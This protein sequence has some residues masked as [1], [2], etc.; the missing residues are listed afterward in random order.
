[1]GTTK[2]QPDASFGTKVCFWAETL[3]NEMKHISRNP[4]TGASEL[5]H[6]A[7]SRS[8]HQPKV[9]IVDPD[10]RALHQAVAVLQHRYRIHDATSF[11]IARRLWETELP[12]VL[13]ADVRLGQFNGLQ[14]LMRARDERPD[15]IAV[16]TCSFADP[17]LEAETRRLGGT[18]MVKPITPHYLLA[19]IE[20]AFVKKFSEAS[21]QKRNDGDRSIL[22]LAR[23]FG[24]Q[25][26]NGSPEFTTNRRTQDRRQIVNRNH[27]PERRVMDRRKA[28]PS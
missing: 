17:V 21:V 26:A 14:L 22:T 25:P 15:L 23:T 27:M 13:V 19:T 18:F 6:F 4:F 11:P 1:V 2:S 28:A 5:R 24:E 9:L 3:A 10:T 20:N 16:I 8:G 7:D 12:E